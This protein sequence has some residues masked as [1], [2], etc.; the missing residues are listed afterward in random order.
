M[1]QKFEPLQPV[2]YAVLFFGT[3]I[4]YN[5]IIAPTI[6]WALKKAFPR[7]RFVIRLLGGGMDYDLPHNREEE[8]PF[9]R[10]NAI[11]EPPYEQDDSD[12]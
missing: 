11:N 12:Y 1:W 2:G 7:S 6:K 3:C 8:E 9:L 5:I 4:Y 10:Q